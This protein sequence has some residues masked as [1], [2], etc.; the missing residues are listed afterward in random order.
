[1]RSGSIPQETVRRGNELGGDPWL[2][3]R[4]PGFEHDSVVGFGP[5][6]MEL[7]CRLDRTHDV[8]AALHDHGRNVAD[9]IYAAQQLLLIG[10]EAAVTEVVSLYAG[11]RERKLRLRELRLTL[12]VRPKRARCAL[13]NRPCARGCKLLGRGGLREPAMVCADQVAALFRRDRREECAP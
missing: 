13:P 1:S 9:A 3:R 5:A 10:E 8:V 7:P 2:V 12:G 11:E 6:L 4:V